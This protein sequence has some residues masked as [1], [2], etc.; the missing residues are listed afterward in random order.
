MRFLVQVKSYSVS[1]SCFVETIC[2]GPLPGQAVLF[3]PEDLGQF[4]D[5]FD[6]EFGRSRFLRQLCFRS[7]WRF[8]RAAIETV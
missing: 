7:W 1:A 8:D 2:L 5:V 4:R 3:V 6:I